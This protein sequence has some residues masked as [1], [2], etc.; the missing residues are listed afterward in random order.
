MEG[1]RQLGCAVLHCKRQSFSRQSLKSVPLKAC[2]SPV[3][4]TTFAK[5]PPK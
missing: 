4:V 2:D 1:L 5:S 3:S